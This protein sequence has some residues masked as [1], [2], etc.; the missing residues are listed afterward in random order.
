MFRNDV[1]LKKLILNLV[2]QIYIFLEIYKKPFFDELISLGININLETNVEIN[3]SGIN[4]FLKNNK[5]KVQLTKD[6]M[7]F[8]CNSPV[9]V[10]KMFL[11]KVLVL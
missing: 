11:K 8:F 1:R 9:S 6:N 10:L 7:V 3:N 2:F 5:E 4:Y